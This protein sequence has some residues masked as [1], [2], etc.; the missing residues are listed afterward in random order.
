MKKTI[1]NFV[2]KH[3]LFGG[4]GAHVDKSGNHAKRATQKQLYEKEIKKE[5]EKM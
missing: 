1:R 3:L 2:A 4:Q 5:L